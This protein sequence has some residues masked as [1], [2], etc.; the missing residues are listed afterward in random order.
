MRI[1]CPNCGSTEQV[2]LMWEESSKYST[3]QV[4]EY[5]CTCGCTFEVTFVASSSVKIL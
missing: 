4:R 2:T 5:E 1:K 3:E